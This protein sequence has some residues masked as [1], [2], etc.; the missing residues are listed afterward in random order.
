MATVAEALAFIDA[1]EGST[2]PSI[3]G[4]TSGSDS[5]DSPVPDKQLLTVSIDS[6]ALK[7]KRKRRSKNPAGYS[8]RLLHRKKAEMQQLREEA[9]QLEAK[10]ENLRRTREVG[11]GALAA[12]ATHLKSKAEFKWME[13]AMIEFQRRQQ[14]EDTN[15][16]LRALVANQAKIDEALRGVVMKKSVLEGMDILNDTP[17]RIRNP[18]AA[19]DNSSVIMTELEKKVAEMYLE[20]ALLF[21]SDTETSTIRCEMKRRV[22]KQLGH[23]V[24]IVSSAPLSCSIEAASSSL[25]KELSTIR[26]YPDKSY[27]Y[28]SVQDAI[29]LLSN[30]VVLTRAYR[31]LLPTDGLQLRGN[32]WTI[33]SRSKT[34][35]SEASDIHAFVQLYM[36]VQPG[37]SARPEDVEYVRDVAFE[38]WTTK[39]RGHAQFLQE[40]LIEAASGAPEGASQLLLKS[41]C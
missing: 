26:A 2:S 13:M 38:T 37:F 25:W 1:C 6:K 20:S 36:E 33:F 19:V 27:R 17:S 39:M 31:M 34:N 7:P 11:V 14:S 29:T 23:T 9:L 30:R 24:E 32:A 41:V 5:G 22:D 18:L 28:V 16:K 15:R 3:N 10:V 4:N 8:T 40:M 12:H 35:P 21:A